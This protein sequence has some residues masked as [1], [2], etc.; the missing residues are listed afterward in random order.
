MKITIEG[1]P[2]EMAALVLQLQERP[3]E[4]YT[5]ELGQ[6]PENPEIRSIFGATLRPA[7]QE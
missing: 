4:K 1:T 7:R 3:A 5:I 2:K 6:N